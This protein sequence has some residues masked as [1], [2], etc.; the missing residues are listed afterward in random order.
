MALTNQEIRKVTEQMSAIDSELQ[1]KDFGLDYVR[2][3]QNRL[4]E[5]CDDI[6][7]VSATVAQCAGLSYSV[8][9]ETRK[10]T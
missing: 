8:R 10:A 7:A 1:G 3:L 6:I 2:G 5:V 9:A 4:K